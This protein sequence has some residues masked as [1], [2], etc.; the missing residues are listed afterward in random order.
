MTENIFGSENHSYGA[1]FKQ[2]LTY[3]DFDGVKDELNELLSRIP[4]D[5][6]MG[7]ASTVVKAKR[8]GID[9]G[10][11]I[12]RSTILSYLYGMGLDVSAPTPLTKLCFW[13][14]R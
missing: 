4:Y 14:L 1:I 11:W 8:L 3:G 13:G 6:F 10:E 9:A 7:A 5:D 2:C 12:Y